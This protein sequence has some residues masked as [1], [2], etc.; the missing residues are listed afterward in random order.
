M[1]ASC[2]LVPRVPKANT[3][4]HVKGL[5]TNTFFPDFLSFS[6]SSQSRVWSQSLREVTEKRIQKQ[7]GT[8]SALYFLQ[9]DA[10]CLKYDQGSAN[11][12]CLR[13]DLRSANTIVY[14][15]WSGISKHYTF[16]RY[17]QES[18][19]NYMFPGIDRCQQIRCALCRLRL[20]SDFK[21]LSC[22]SLHHSYSALPL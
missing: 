15:V 19:K 6:G 22:V 21:Y 11:T 16:I 14:Q 3:W 13:C 2:E 7:R 18:A 9:W 8:G 20:S 12:M 10:V 17:D 1:T 5:N 4:T